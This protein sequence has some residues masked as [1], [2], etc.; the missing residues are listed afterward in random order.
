MLSYDINEWHIR[1]KALVFLLYAI[2]HFVHH[3]CVTFSTRVETLNF[4]FLSERKA[5]STSQMASECF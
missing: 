1:T 5:R 2:H 4:M 3:S